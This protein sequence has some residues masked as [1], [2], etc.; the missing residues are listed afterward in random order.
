MSL[1]ERLTRSDHPLNFLRP[2]CAV[3]C[4]AI[5]LCVSGQTAA[6]SERPAF[7]IGTGRLAT[8][9]SPAEK[10][11]GLRI[12]NAAQ[13][14]GWSTAIADFNTDGRPDFAVADHT[15]RRT[16]GF[17]YRIEFS[18]AGEASRLV[19]FES[20]HEAVTIH[21]ADVD[22][23]NDL[24]LVVGAPASGE[25][26]GVWLNDGAGHFTSSDIRHAPAAIRAVQALGTGAPSGVVRAAELP[27]RETGP[28]VPTAR[29]RF[30]RRGVRRLAGSSAENLPSAR[31]PSPI[32]LRAPPES[33][34][35]FP[36]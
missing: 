27:P 7:P 22:R 4:V 19:T 24:D 18:I 2:I 13:P 15:G 12:G 14:F 20:T 10:H 36:L 16:D 34:L 33:A 23:D 26:V 25:T 8:C 21:V 31:V 29:D 28:G 32:R 9:W 5:V 6:R 11:S 1:A 17:G 30:S 3:A 35:N